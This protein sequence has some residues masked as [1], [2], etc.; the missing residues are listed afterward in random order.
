MST[1]DSVPVDT[2]GGAFVGGD[3][4]AARDFIGRDQFNISLHLQQV[5]DAAR[6]ASAVSA[7]LTQTD[8]VSQSIR[9]DLLSVM[10]EL[11]RTHS[12]L[13]KLVSPLRRVKDSAATFADEFEAVYNDFRDFYDVYDFAEERTRCHKLRQIGQR[14]DR[15]EAPIT[16]TPEWANL[17]ADLHELYDLDINLIE[18]FY[19]PFTD[20]FNNVMVRIHEHIGKQEIGQAIALKQVFLA[21]LSPQYDAIKGRLRFM[22]DAMSGIEDALD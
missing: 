2:G 3:V 6:V 9:S 13:V 10:E 19:R 16:R 15:H 4:Q 11:R 8:P 17:Q 18:G 5:D 12:T 20:R 22:T 14:L 1:G 21:E 7:A